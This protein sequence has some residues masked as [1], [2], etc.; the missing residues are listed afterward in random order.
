MY[1][2]AVRFSPHTHTHA[3][4]YIHTYT[5]DGPLRV[6][7][8]KPATGKRPDASTA[9]RPA[10]RDPVLA[11]LVSLGHRGSI[12]FA[13][14]PRVPPPGRR[15]SVAR[16]ETEQTGDCERNWDESRRAGWTRREARGG[17]EGG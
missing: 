10:A 3:R 8:E 1:R 7:P 9:D 6:L 15:G 17:G 14:I 12:E 16:A 5:C 4:V 13:E 11:Y 2:P